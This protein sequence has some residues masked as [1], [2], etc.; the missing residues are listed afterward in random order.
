MTMRLTGLAG[1]VAAATLVAAPAASAKDFGPGDLRLCNATRCVPIEHRGALRSLS[2]FYYTRPGNLVVRSPRLGA[3]IYELRFRN[4]YVTGIVAGFMLDRFLSY[5]VN[6]ERFRRGQWY[7][8]PDVA[9]A[10]L[11]RLANGLTPQRLTRAAV[12]KSR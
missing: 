8:V 6:L 11:R 5:G 1:V 2:S 4:G 9:A 3:P 12:A 10:E 7:R